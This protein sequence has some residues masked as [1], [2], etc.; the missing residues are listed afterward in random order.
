M[1]KLIWV[2]GILV[3]LAAGYALFAMQGSPVNNKGKVSSEPTTPTP[4]PTPT[5]SPAPTPTPTPVSPPAQKDMSADDANPLKQEELVVGKGTEANV[6]DTV[7]VQYIGKLQNGTKFD[8]SY[9]HGKPFE[10]TIG[11]GEVIKGWEMGVPGMKVGGKRKLTIAPSLA[12]GPNGLPPV[13]PPNATLV[14]EIELLAVKGSI[15]GG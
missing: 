5:V 3:V 6:G 8:S 9:D 4:V 7:S 10:F 1:N 14:F 11:K 12:Y 2:V 13:I 15:G